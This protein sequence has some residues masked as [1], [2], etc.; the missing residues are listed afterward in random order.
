MSRFIGRPIFAALLTLLVLA[1]AS[2]PVAAQTAPHVTVALIDQLPDSAVATIVR[3]P[4]TNGG[5]V[6]L[7]RTRD[8]DVSTLASAMMAMYKARQV[9]GDTV[10][11]RLVLRVYG[12]RPVSSLAP[13]EHRLAQY[14]I[15]RLRTAREA[16]VENL[17]FLKSVQVTIVPA[18]STIAAR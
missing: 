4:G 8:A 13:N 18:S 7:L 5:T 1:S 17:G 14:Y 16:P 2:A 6:V 12:K 10:Q 11:S 15:D 3:S 9:L